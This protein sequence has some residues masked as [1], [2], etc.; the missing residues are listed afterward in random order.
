MEHTLTALNLTGT[1]PDR[2]DT[3]PG[4]EEL[5]SRLVLSAGGWDPRYAVTLAVASADDVGAALIDTNGDEADIDLDGYQRDADGG[6]EETSSSGVGDG[7]CFLSNRMAVIFGRTGP[8]LMVDI[9]YAGQRGSIVASA[10]GWWL[11]VAV[12]I[13][14]SDAVPSFVGTRPAAR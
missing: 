13:A 8:G 14:G 5:N 1:G 4:V 10:T 7:G 11:Y 6:W 9:E 3:M 2:R 12:A